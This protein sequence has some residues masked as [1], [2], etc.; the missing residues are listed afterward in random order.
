MEGMLRL[1][2]LALN[3]LR[4]AERLSAGASRITTTALFTVGAVM[5]LVIGFGC[6]ITAAWIALV[7]LVGAVSAALIA[8][9]CFFIL[10]AIMWL[11]A[12]ARITEGRDHEKKADHDPL[13]AIADLLGNGPDSDLKRLLGENK[14]PIL[15]AALVAGLTLGGSG[16]RR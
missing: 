13:E 3:V 6:L 7:P 9:A 16:R 8:G 11:M 14:L 10:S 2:L 4:P 15:L 5:A 1:A 12:R